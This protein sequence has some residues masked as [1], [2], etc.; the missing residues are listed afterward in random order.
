MSLYASMNT[1]ISGLAA[2]ARALGNVADN[3]AN[4]QTTGFKRTDTNF[5]AYVTRSNL[6]VNQPG[7]VTARPD[8]TNSVQGTV[9]QSDNPL[10]MAIAGQGMFAVAMPR[11][12]E[13]GLPT[14]DAR[15]YYTRAGDFNMDTD[16]Y[17]VNGQGYYLQGWTADTEGNPDRSSIRPLR[18]DQSV[19]NP[20]ATGNVNLSANLPA[21][22]TTVP[23]AAQIQIYD[24]LGRLHSVDMTWT[25]TGTNTWQLSMAI[26]DDTS[27]VTTRTINVNFG[28]AASATTPAGTIGSFGTAVGLTGSAAVA[29]DPAAVTFT[30]DFGQGVQTVQLNLGTFGVASG[31]TQYS[32]QEYTLRD[33]SQDGVPLGSFSTVSLNDNGDL[34][35][36]YDNGQSRVIGRVPIVTFSDPDKLQKTDGQAY[37]RTEESG[38]ARANDASSNGSGK[39]V[40]SSLESSNVDIASE[41]SKLILAQRAYSANTKIVTAADEL[42]QDTLNMRR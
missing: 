15:T 31:V 20:V 8:Y 5:V 39:I 23:V 33:I 14:F 3:V 17:L 18:V 30:A 13:D 36:N 2:Q 22:S 35:V 41:F 38:E 16:G 40:S 11:G 6:Q 34:A 27:G 37:L 29:G 26:P 24:S 21:D 25:N 28:A 42:L 9:Q 32:G 7:S 4:S 1:A 19:Y 10:A 12:T